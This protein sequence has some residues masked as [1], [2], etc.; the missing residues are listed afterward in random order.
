MKIFS[1]QSRNFLFLMVSFFALPLLAL[2]ETEA[3]QLMD[4]EETYIYCDKNHS[5]LPAL[6]AEIAQFD[7]D[8]NSPVWQ[9]HRHIEEGF[10][11]GRQDAIIDALMYAEEVVFKHR[12]LL[13]NT[14]LQ[15]IQ[16]TLTS[17]T[18]A[19]TGDLLNVDLLD[20][21]PA[22]LGNPT[23]VLR[24]SPLKVRRKISFYNDVKFK[25]DVTFEDKALFEDSVKFKKR[26]KFEDNVTIEG[27]LSA[28]DIVASGSLTVMDIT[29]DE[30][31]ALCNLTVGCNILMDNSTDA[32]EGNIL[33]NNI[34]FIHNFGP[35]NTFTG[36]N[37]GN[38]TMTGGSN[39]GFGVNTLLANTTGIFNIA[40]GANA[41]SAN[42]TGES[43]TAIGAGNLQNNTIGL[44]N[45][46]VGH[47][48]LNANVTGSANTAL[49]HNALNAHLVDNTV[50]V[51]V[52]ALLLNTT[53]TEN[54]AV[55]SFA[56][57]SNITGS[58]NT[59]L[60]NLAL[61]TN[62]S[63][64]DNIGIGNNVG[65]GLVSGSRNIYIN[66]NPTAVG[67]SDTTRIGTTQTRAFIA[68]IRGAI[69]GIAD[70]IAVLVD[71]A[72]QLG[73]ISS[74]IE[75]KHNIAD[76]SDDSA[77]LLSLNPVKFTYKNDAKN[78]TQYGLLAEEVN[79]VLPELVSMGKNGK[80]ETVKYHL[81]SALLIK[82]LQKQHESIM[83][84]KDA[85]QSILE[86]LDLLEQ[87]IPA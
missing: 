23:D 12:D 19:V 7:Q 58:R 55:G 49:G 32:T 42:T 51:G 6:I 65:S 64:N 10:T 31:N 80:P 1:Q 56:L 84:L 18:D 13:H 87:N 24:L 16:T 11:I 67:E 63:G 43:N 85:V 47:N 52:D 40:I 50:A 37:A 25:E 79:K 35:N 77:K 29:A 27:T 20:I 48:V 26:V 2:S 3:L 74:S 68:G 71:S 34:R 69:T 5:N 44:I 60:G 78:I 15:N 39:C 73:T 62:V 41:L 8:Q 14:V 33:K 4:S 45:T 59:V 72:G 83:T 57:N 9:L 70:G 38:F 54:T 21:D 28:A 22:D 82:E 75:F 86:R 81:L 61:E 17:V 53:G 66:A 76:L 46:A 30:I 36:I